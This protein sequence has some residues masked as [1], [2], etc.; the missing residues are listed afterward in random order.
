VSNPKPHPKLYLG[1]SGF[2]Y[3][4]WKGSFYPTDLKPAAM[5]RYYAER[6]SAVE[7]NA[8]FYRMPTEATLEAWLLQVP[9]GFTFVLKAPQRITHQLRLV[10]AEQVAQRFTEI[11]QSLGERLG[12]LLFQLPPNFKKD[13]GKLGAFLDLLPRGQ[14]LS[15]EFRSPTWFDAE[16]LQLLRDRGVALCWEQAEEITAPFES[17]ADIGY[18]RLRLP[19][20][21]DAALKGWVD[22][23]R[24]QSWKE[25]FVFFKHEDEGK[26][27]QFAERFQRIWD[28]S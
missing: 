25:V 7:I 15:F 12:L 17:T 21:D 2:S 9:P 13:L 1:T 3:P 26:G 11:A 19:E 10:G 28:A 22:R 16:T 20:Y 5:L 23:I 24:A 6:F 8:T 14:K 18:L 4:A 27:P